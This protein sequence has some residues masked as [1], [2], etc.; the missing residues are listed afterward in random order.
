MNKIKS[1]NTNISL[2]PQVQANLP[3][4]SKSSNWRQGCY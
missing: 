4:Y 3:K 1:K 2:P